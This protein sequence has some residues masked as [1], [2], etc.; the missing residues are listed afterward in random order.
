MKK[1][2]TVLSKHAWSIAKN[3][4]DDT[5]APASSSGFGKS[6]RVL[7]DSQNSYDEEMLRNEQQLEEEVMGEVAE[8]NA[9]KSQVF[10]RNLNQMVDVLHLRL[11]ALEGAAKLRLEFCAEDLNPNS[12]KESKSVPKIM[13]EFEDQ[14]VNPRILKETKVGGGGNASKDTNLVSADGVFID[15]VKLIIKTKQQTET[16]KKLETKLE[17]LFSSSSLREMKGKK[18]KSSNR[19]ARSKKTE[20]KR[21]EAK[22][23]QRIRLEKELTANMENYV[24]RSVNDIDLD[25]HPPQ[26]P[27]GDITWPISIKWS[28]HVDAS[29]TAANDYAEGEMNPELLLL[30]ALERISIPGGEYMFQKL[31][32]NISVQ[33]YFVCLFWLVKM[34][35]FVND[36]ECGT[37]RVLLKKLSSEYVK[38]V[39]VLSKKSH[40][41]NNKDFVF[42]YLPFIISNAIYYTFYF[43][44]PGSRHMYSKGFRKTILMQVVQVM[45]GVQLCPVS[46]RVAWAKLFPEEEQEDVTLD[47]EE[48]DSIPM[49]IPLTFVKR[50]AAETSDFD[51]DAPSASRK[52]PLLHESD[53]DH[54]FQLPPQAGARPKKSPLP[55]GKKSPDASSFPPAAHESPLGLSA[56]QTAG[57]TK[58]VDPVSRLSLHPPPAKGKFLVPR[59]R[60]ERSDVNDISPLMQQ[61]LSL[62]NSG[63]YKRT[64]TLSRTVPVNW[65]VAGGSDTHRR[66]QIPKELHDELSMKS[67]SISRDIRR[68]TSSTHLK[69]VADGRSLDKMCSTIIGA[70]S[71]AVGRYSQ[72]L[73]KKLKKCRGLSEIEGSDETKVQSIALAETDDDIFHD[74]MALDGLL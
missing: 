8:S 3:Y 7:L 65:C 14:H 20:A 43:L 62:P 6:S 35:F 4:H 22:K 47:G 45:H 54:D 46:V 38:I 49:M 2:K 12:M 44:C 13:E 69:K 74:S 29:H 48:N 52:G 42:Q 68:I 11:R 30:Y 16:S 73:V 9:Q 56:S 72:D 19:N 25:F 40:G 5:A 23:M 53:T 1:S 64:Q 57:G 63:G 32:K 36:K 28:Q 41:E 71:G 24:T 21:Y 18:S 55:P 27:D 34:K 15:P 10:E 39:E 70:G 66:R 58:F 26:H 61:Y 67:K 33:T 59:Q 37:E 17:D 60:R 31:F 50:E 51:R